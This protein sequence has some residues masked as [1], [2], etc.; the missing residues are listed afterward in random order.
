MDE[1]LTEDQLAEQKKHA[2]SKGK[3][4]RD[5]EIR[6]LKETLAIPEGMS[7]LR[8]IMNSA[9]FYAPMFEANSLKMAK[10]VAAHD[11]L[12]WL[13][14]DLEK[15]QPGMTLFISTDTRQLVSGDLELVDTVPGMRRFLTRFILKL[16]SYRQLHRDVSLDLA[17]RVGVRDWCMARLAELDVLAPGLVNKLCIEAANGTVP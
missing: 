15:C 2:K 7:L 6:D 14:A 1:E 9:G 13:V 5:R 11:W 4:K 10:N 16:G 12:H 8:W 17:Q 3:L